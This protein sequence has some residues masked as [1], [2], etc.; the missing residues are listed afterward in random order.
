MKKKK[1]E[2]KP[3][4]MP[5][6]E[7][8]KDDAEG[9]VPEAE[10]VPM[11]QFMRLQADFDNFRKRTQRERLDYSRQANEKLMEELLPVLDHFQ[12]GLETARQHPTDK[13]VIEGLELVY[14]QMLGALA[15]FGLTPVDADGEV[16]DPH[17]HEA[18]TYM[19]S[20]EY[21]AEHVMTQ[22][23]RG[24]KLGNKLLRAAQV[25]VSSGPMDATATA[26][27]DIID[28]FEEEESS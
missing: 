20:D 3:E 14:N 16:F 15:R 7:S 5:P 2:K 12:L 21:P 24:Y 28:A 1:T 27:E 9:D 11:S 22:T 17:H 19:P 13:S 23:R 8:P 10:T 25:V 26:K 6:P 4:D 18:I